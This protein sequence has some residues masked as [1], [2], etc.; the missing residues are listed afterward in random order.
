M[1]TTILLSGGGALGAFQAGAL[2]ALQPAIDDAQFDRPA[3]MVGISVGALNATLAALNHHDWGWVANHWHQHVR[4]PEDIA[5]RKSPVTR[6]LP[7]LLRG[8]FDGLVDTAPLRGMLARHV[9]VAML[10]KSPIAVH[11]GAVNLDTG[12]LSYKT[13]L[14]PDFLDHLLASSAIPLVFPSVD[15][16][17]EAWAD[18]GLVEVA[19]ATHCIGLG[20]DRIIAILCQSERPERQPVDAGNA[21]ALAERLMDIVTISLLEKDVR[22]IEGVNRRIRDAERDIKRKSAGSFVPSRRS[23]FERRGLTMDKR[24][25]DV[26][27][28]RP[29]APLGYNTGAFTERDIARA[30][31]MGREAGAAFVEGERL[32]RAGT[33]RAA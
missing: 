8:R 24:L 11:A 9:S 31:D 22:A 17:G 12:A 6:I 14:H 30:L 26:A 4:R 18:G 3:H 19:P 33:V 20:A 13:Q 28:I 23:E 15:I 1:T 27:I 16:N 32:A 25:I 21:L 29:P 5:T 2:A 10:R 7:G